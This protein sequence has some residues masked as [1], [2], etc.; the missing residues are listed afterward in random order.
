[1]V[2]NISTFIGHINITPAKDDRQNVIFILETQN[3][4]LLT[5]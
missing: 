2:T 1:M 5:T 3:M 4:A